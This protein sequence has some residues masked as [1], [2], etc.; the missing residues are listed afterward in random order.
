MISANNVR[1]NALGVM[2]NVFGNE[3][4]NTAALPCLAGGDV[5]LCLLVNAIQG[6]LKAG[7]ITVQWTADGRYAN[8][9]FWTANGSCND[10]S[11]AKL[12]MAWLPKFDV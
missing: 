1:I 10:H 5:F 9:L 12:S 4:M 7:G 3:D 8:F 6:E 11:K 2:T